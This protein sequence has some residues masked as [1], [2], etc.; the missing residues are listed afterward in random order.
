[1][2]YLKYF[3]GMKDTIED[4]NDIC[5]ELS[6]KG[7][8]IEVNGGSGYQENKYWQKLLIGKTEHLMP[9][10][11]L[12]DNKCYQYDEIKEVVERLKQYL[13]DRLKNIEVCSIDRNVDE[14]YDQIHDKIIWNK[15]SNK[16]DAVMPNYWYLYHVYSVKIEF[17][18]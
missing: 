3:E 6:D 1:M 7:F 9:D 14:Y 16:V 5:L 18:L 17:I 13:G 4:I 2:K 15:L 8:I 10:E 12:F 11:E